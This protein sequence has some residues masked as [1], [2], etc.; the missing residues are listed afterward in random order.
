M[1]SYKK[2][3]I[4]LEFTDLI[5]IYVG[6]ARDT[7]FAVN[8]TAEVYLI[9]EYKYIHFPKNNYYPLVYSD[10]FQHLNHVH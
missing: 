8:H 9:H 10:A 3:I 2:K 4:I 5:S 1:P 7:D 6:D